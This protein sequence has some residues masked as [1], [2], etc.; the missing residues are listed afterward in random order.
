MLRPA[1][2]LLASDGLARLPAN[3]E[4]WQRNL[5]YVPQD[6]FLHDSSIA[7]NI[8]LGMNAWEIDINAVE[9][10]ARIA[11]LHDFVTQELPNGVMIYA[12]RRAWSAV[13]A[14]NGNA[15]ASPGLSTET[16]ACLY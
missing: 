9:Q 4:S 14:V 8:S 7:A 15:L 10:S 2:G 16:R 1:E 5:G 11:L 12:N 3:I 13:K 6:I